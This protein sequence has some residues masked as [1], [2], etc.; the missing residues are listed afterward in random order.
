MRNKWV[1]TVSIFAFCIPG[2]IKDRLPLTDGVNSLAHVALGAVAAR[3]PVAYALVAVCLFFWYQLNGR[4]NKFTDN[5]EFTLGFI[6]SRSL[7]R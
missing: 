5:Y 3:L 4:N 1:P 2:M 7:L 6:V